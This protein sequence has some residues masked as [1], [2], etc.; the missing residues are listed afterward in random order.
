MLRLLSYGTLKLGD[1]SQCP[2]KPVVYGFDFEGRGRAKIAKLKLFKV[3]Q[4]WDILK[5]GLVETIKFDSYLKRKALND[6]VKSL[7]VSLLSDHRSYFNS[8]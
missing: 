7:L 6:V 3:Y 1:Q 8:F 2:R 4:F 5:K